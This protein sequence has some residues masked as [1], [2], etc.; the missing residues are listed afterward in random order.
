MVIMD[1]ITSAKEIETVWT[2]SLFG[3]RESAEYA[4]LEKLLL[5]R[6]YRF[7]LLNVPEAQQR[8]HNRLSMFKAGFK[9]RIN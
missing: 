4:M 5:V 1:K 7:N 2:K 3:Y 6:D 9:G 8:R